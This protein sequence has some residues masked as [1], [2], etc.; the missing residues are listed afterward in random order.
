MSGPV[1]K[2]SLVTRA[3]ATGII[4]GCTIASC[5]LFDIDS[6]SMTAMVG[7]IRADRAPLGQYFSFERYAEGSGVDLDGPK[8]T[9][10]D[11]IFSQRSADSTLGQPFAS[12]LGSSR[13]ESLV[14]GPSSV[15]ATYEQPGTSGATLLRGSFNPDDVV[16]RIDTVLRQ[17][18]G[19]ANQGAYRPP[20]LVTTDGED[21]FTIISVEGDLVA[22]TGISSNTSLAVSEDEML[23][24]P[25]STSTADVLVEDQEQSR[26]D[27]DAVRDVAGALDDAEVYAAVLSF[28]A[29]AFDGGEQALAGGFGSGFVDGEER[30]FT[31]LAHEADAA[32]TANISALKKTMGREAGCK[33]PVAV[34]VEGQVALA[35]CRTDG[36]RWAATVRDGLDTSGPFRFA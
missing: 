21:G 26:L 18:K 30:S 17:Q 32:V 34:T 8:A 10:L 33:G 24:L 4:A 23:S 6:G 22:G 27:V 15:S 19:E 16:D 29:V 14:I 28:D 3:L 5:G 9:V 12:S 25:G 13:P 20:E 31:V 2:L 36:A 1:R 35:S 11:E 7:S